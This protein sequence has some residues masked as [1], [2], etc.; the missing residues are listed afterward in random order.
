VKEE[1]VE[2]RV[3]EEGPFP[4]SVWTPQ[5]KPRA[6]VLL[7]HGLGVDRTH[8]T[9]QMPAE[10]LVERLGL[11]VVAPDLPRHGVRR[12]GAGDMASVTA[13][14]QAY[15]TSGG[16]ASLR[17]E[18]VRIAAF[19][20]ERFG[21][22]RLGY[23]GLSLA[24]QYGVVFLS[25]A[26]QIAAAVL[27]LFGSEPPPKSAIMNACAPRVQCP[28]YFIQ[29]QDDEIHPRASTDHLYATLGS[30]EKVLDSS[31]GRH[32]AVS[33]ETLARACRFLAERL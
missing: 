24:T 31:P 27:G 26:P 8:S 9:V 33:P 7:G 20:R 14:W 29:K 22:S 2:L 12:E 28:I 17:D 19:A 13:A 16:A 18:W 1:V 5:A 15:W 25:N 30:A 23:F 32:A 21:G 11:A 10:Y 6:V 4:V 3:E